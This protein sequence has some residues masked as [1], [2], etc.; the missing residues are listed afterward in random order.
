MGDSPLQFA[1]YALAFLAGGAALAVVLMLS[2]RKRQLDKV[3]SNWQARLDDMTRRRDRQ[4]AECNS[5]RTRLE[6]QQATMHKHDVAVAKVRTELESA[7]EREKRL[8]KDNFTMRGEREEFKKTLARFQAAMKSVKQ[9]A[10]DLQTEFSKSR[11]FFKGELLK[12]FEKRKDL[13]Q[14]LENAR[15]EHESFTNLL[16]SSRS[17]QDAINRMLSSSQARLANM[18]NLERD[19]IRLEAEN[20]QANH[21]LRLANQE[22]ETLRR[23]VAELDE[24]KV[25]NR[26]LAHCLE[27]MEN[28]RKQYESDAQR[29][30]NRANEQEQKSETLRIRVDELEQSFA[31]IEN[32]QRKALKEA[33]SQAA[34]G[35][36]NGR[37][38]TEIEKDDLQQIVGIGK[39]F[40]RALND[41]GIYNFRQ[42]AAFGPAEI[43]RV[44]GA[45]KEI[46]G[47]MEQDDWIGQAKELMYSKYAERIEQA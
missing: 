4:V 43:A 47:R 24:L 5:L 16:Q 21:D 14:K 42:I 35:K 15:L 31:D 29:Y 28:S 30:R 3:D 39:V 23:D 9:Q 40:E 34:N 18:D 22:I 7:R 33:R 13:E 17:E 26:E 27:S 2:L 19:V 10:T 36:S 1:A 45:L 8:T 6:E 38:D 46:R 20:A 44:N 37:I 25:Q 41:L 12:S 32:Q 11:E